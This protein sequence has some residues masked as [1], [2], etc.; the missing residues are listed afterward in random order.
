MKPTRTSEDDNGVFHRI[1]NPNAADAG[2]DRLTPEQYDKL[3]LGILAIRPLP[4]PETKPRT[5]LNR[6]SRPQSICPT[7]GCKPGEYHAVGCNPFLN[8]VAG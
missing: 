8:E 7:C 1:E 5:A 2:Y 3:R 4:P 6:G